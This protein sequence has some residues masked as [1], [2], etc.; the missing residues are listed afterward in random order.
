MEGTSVPWKSLERLTHKM[1]LT[2]KDENG[3]SETVSARE[4]P[5]AWHSF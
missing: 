4:M 1:N 3:A 5:V 2:L